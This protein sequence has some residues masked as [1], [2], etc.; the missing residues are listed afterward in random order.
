MPTD[1]SQQFIPALVA[2]AVVGHVA[3]T[4]PDAVPVLALCTGVFATV[5]AVLKL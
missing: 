5:A 3:T 2:T 4:H 1:G